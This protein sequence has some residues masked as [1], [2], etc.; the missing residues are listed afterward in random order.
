M[1]VF[2]QETVE[3]NSAAD[4]AMFRV[5]LKEGRIR[6]L[7]I[8]YEYDKTPCEADWF[9]HIEEDGSIGECENPTV[10]PFSGPFSDLKLTSVDFSIEI[11]PNCTSLRGLFADQKDLKHVEAIENSGHVRNFNYMF[12]DCFH[13]ASVPLLDLFS[14][15][16]VVGMF[17][18]CHRLVTSE[19][20]GGDNVEN[21]SGMFE[22]CYRLHR[23]PEL[24]FPN[25]KI[26]SG[27]FDSCV[28][29]KKVPVYYFPEVRD[30]ACMFQ[31]CIRLKTVPNLHFPKAVNFI[32]MFSNCRSLENLPS[33]IFSFARNNSSSLLLCCFDGC[34]SLEKSDVRFLLR[35]SPDALLSWQEAVL[36]REEMKKAI[37][38]LKRKRKH[39]N[40]HWLSHIIIFAVLLGITVAISAKYWHENQSQSKPAEE[41]IS[42]QENM[43]ISRHEAKRNAAIQDEREIIENYTTRCL[44]DHITFE[45][46]TEDIL[47]KSVNQVGL[48]QSRLYHLATE[49]DSDKFILIIANR[50]A[51]YVSE[52]I[53][54]EPGKHRI[55]MMKPID[56]EAADTSMLSLPAT[57]EELNGGSLDLASIQPILNDTDIFILGGDGNYTLTHFKYKRL[58]VD[59]SD[60]LFY[61]R[62][63]PT[64][65]KENDTGRYMVPMPLEGHYYYL[66][67]HNQI[68]DERLPGCFEVP[69]NVYD[70]MGHGLTYRQAAGL[71][72]D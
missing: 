34:V 65:L 45:R 44:G 69:Q 49:K 62:A 41:P 47:L 1:S 67:A 20:T 33:F 9:S 53:V 19:L 66:D 8:N 32:Q 12:S 43:V 18:G 11:G 56:L 54:F 71:A 48:Y 15:S 60:K 26:A 63:I 37:R 35:N 51:S 36:D 52:P 23:A 58:P 31:D 64:L 59:L 17:S 3:L 27:M 6:R 50:N 55:A 16:S 28:S 13:L 4:L 22:Y 46:Y 38:D 70:G 2:M 40:H 29:L 42:D 7:V 21:C 68:S 5:K 14:A 10:E 39:E 30:C 57:P 24:F 72:V 25:C 61:Q